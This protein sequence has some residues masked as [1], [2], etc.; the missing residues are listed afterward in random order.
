VSGAYRPDGGERSRLRRSGCA[1]SVSLRAR[2]RLAR[3]WMAD[4]PAALPIA[5]NRCAAVGCADPESV[6]AAPAHQDSSVL[7]GGFFVG[8]QGVE[9][10]SH[11]A[12]VRYLP[13]RR[14]P[15]RQCDPV[16]PFQ[17]SGHDIAAI[18]AHHLADAAK[19]TQH[20]VATSIALV[21]RAEL[22]RP[23]AHAINLAE[24]EGRDRGLALMA[25]RGGGAPRRMACATASLK[26]QGVAVAH[27]IPA[28]QPRIQPAPSTWPT[29]GDPLPARTDLLLPWQALTRREDRSYRA[30]SNHDDARPQRRP[31]LAQTTGQ[32]QDTSQARP[33]WTSQL[34]PVAECL[35][36][37]A[38]DRP[39]G[40]R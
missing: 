8:D 38:Q 9:T 34:Q 18:R 22:G 10:P 4:L 36:S 35:A 2:G 3:R 11:S 21:V 32:A 29:A 16:W 33:P 17:Q 23:E 25:P 24:R 28:L 40:C 7:V 26:L 14:Y 37:A 6:M 30:C 31:G 15:S 1:G 5:P 27:P 39:A 19:I 20:P 12:A 13:M